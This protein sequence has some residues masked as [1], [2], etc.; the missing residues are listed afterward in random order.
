VRISFIVPAFNEAATIGEVL[1]RIAA[2]ELD[3]QV[4]VDDGS[5]DRTAE[6]VD[7]RRRDREIILIRQEHRG[8]GAAVRTAIPHVRGTSRLSRMPTWSTTRPTCR[9]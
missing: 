5:T 1:H 7:E 6:I 3:S 8:K 2:L 9:H 4:V